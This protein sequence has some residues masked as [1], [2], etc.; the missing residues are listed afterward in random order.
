MRSHLENRGH[1]E[2]RKNTF[3]SL[4]QGFSSPQL[5]SLKT[6]SLVLFQLSLLP[7]SLRKQKQPEQTLHQLPP[8]ASVQILS[9]L[10]SKPGHGSQS[11]KVTAKIFTVTYKAL[12]HLGPCDISDLISTTLSPYSFHISHTV[13]FLF[14][15]TQ[16]A[17]SYRRAFTPAVPCNWNV[18]PVREPA[19]F[20]PRSL[21]RCHLLSE[22]FPDHTIK[23]YY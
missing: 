23:N 22:A 19:P 2:A 4:G 16:E 10:C 9:F 3:E 11:L 17:H 12:H 8:P 14:P 13:S 21:V 6:S 5:S 18:L 15:Q 20:S 7:I 1:S